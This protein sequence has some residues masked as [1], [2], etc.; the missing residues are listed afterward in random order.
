[1]GRPEFFNAAAHVLACPGRNTDHIYLYLHVKDSVIAE[2]RWQCHM[3]DPWIMIAG[4]MVCRLIEGRRTDQI[5]ALT[6]A[7]FEAVLGGQDYVIAHHTGAATLVA[8]KA[9]IDYSIKEILKSDQPGK[10][11]P[12]SLLKDLGYSGRE[13]QLRIKCLLETRF[14]SEELEFPRARLEAV[15]SSGTV[16][17]V[18]TLVQDLLERKAI[19]LI[20]ANGLGFPRSFDEAIDTKG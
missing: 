20:K 6:L 19:A 4:D 12:K 13:G 15:C 16:Q 10:V 9:G 2:A 14:S 5:L 18:S 8:Y 1:M 3:G 7:E 11:G 17:E